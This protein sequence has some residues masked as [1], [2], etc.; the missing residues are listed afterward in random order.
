MV[1]GQAPSPRE[2]RKTARYPLAPRHVGHPPAYRPLRQARWTGGLPASE[3]LQSLQRRAGNRAVLS[4]VLG[5]SPTLDRVVQR[6]PLG[7]KPDPTPEAVSLDTDNL[8]PIKEYIE[9]QAAAGRRDLIQI[10]LDR[11]RGLDPGALAQIQGYVSAAPFVPAAT[12]E[13]PNT[14][15]AIWMGK[16]IKSTAVTNI[17][18]LKEKADHF[19]LWTDSNHRTFLDTEEAEPLRRAMDQE[20]LKI[21][22]V[23]DLIDDRLTEIYDFA[24]EPEVRPGGDP[25]KDEDKVVAYS[26]ASD[27]ARYSI[28]LRR[29]GV[30][31][32][33]DLSFGSV[34][35]L[36]DLRLPAHGL[37]LLGPNIRDQK[38]QDL[39]LAIDMP[40][41]LAKGDFARAS[42][43]VFLSSQVTKVV[44]S[45]FRG[46]LELPRDEA[47]EER[48]TQEQL[49]AMGRPENLEP[50]DKTKV[51]A[52]TEYLM[53]KYA[54][55]FIAAPPNH[56]FLDFIIG[57]ISRNLNRKNYDKAQVAALTGPQYFSTA[58]EA[59]YRMNY[60]VSGLMP[61]ERRHMIDPAALASVVDLGWLTAESENQIG[62]ADQ[63]TY[64]GRS[65]KTV[66]AIVAA[67]VAIGALAAAWYASRATSSGLL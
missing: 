43:P 2:E 45:A 56:A 18:A 25:S 22:N 49:K 64:T 4:L 48:M 10:L 40:T 38:A 32:D 27:L 30:Y 58:I 53:G 9:A 61:E 51:A 65:A 37:P 11:V 24:L 66:L 62:K 29:G 44:D 16:K 7:I 63:P 8:G 57:D 20:G 39:I 60:G 13:V 3:S 28:L 54:N 1:H 41:L 55:Q 26:M 50:T 42:I 52:R 67:A 21:E 15:H 23:G 19:T 46:L 47:P 31:M 5:Q 6:K 14:I 34:T 12:L 36:P 33:V 35:S 59:Y 17:L